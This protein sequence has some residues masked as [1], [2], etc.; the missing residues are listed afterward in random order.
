MGRQIIKKKNGLFAVWTTIC[1]NFLM[2]DVTQEEMI[3]QLSERA[4]EDEIYRLE[5][6]L[7]HNLYI[8]TDYKERCDLR[9]KIHGKKDEE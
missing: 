5:I 1:D 8:R 6:Q 2:D 3:D 7:K 9:D 4:K